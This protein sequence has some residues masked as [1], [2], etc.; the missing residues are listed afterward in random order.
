MF[1]QVSDG[2]FVTS[3]D[4]HYLDVKLAGSEMLGMTRD[5]VLRSSFLDLLAPA[6]DTGRSSKRCSKRPE[7]SHRCMSP[8]LT[9]PAPVGWVWFSS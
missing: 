2:I 7:P 5:E 4:G 1:E 3:P 6:E 9:A 8:R